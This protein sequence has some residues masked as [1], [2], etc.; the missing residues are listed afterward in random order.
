MNYRQAVTWSATIQEVVRD[1]RMPPWHA[2]PKYGR[3][4]N[5]PGLTKQERQRIDHWIQAG[6]PEGDPADL[7][8]QAVF[9][10]GW[11]IPNPNLVV[12]MPQA[13][14]VPADGVV[15]YHVVEVDP[16]FQEDKWIQTA[17]IRPGNRKVVHHC[18]VFLKAP[19]SELPTEQGTLGSFCL[20]ATT[21]G[22]PPLVLPPGMAKK[23]PAGWTFV[24]VVHYQ[25]IGSVQSD[26]TSIG[27]VFVDPRNVQKEVA[28]KLL[29]DLDFVIPP[30]ASDVRVEQS[31]TFFDDVLLLA[32]LPHM[33]VRGKSF[34]YE[35]VYPDGQGEILLDVP[36]YDFNWQHR[37]VLAEAKRLPA[38]TTLRCIATYDNSA[39]NPW[40]PDPDATVRVGRQSNDE[41]FNGYFEWCLADQDLTQPRP[42]PNTLWA[43]VRTVLFPAALMVAAYGGLLLLKRR[44]TTR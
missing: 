26:Q 33:H 32:M 12:S 30:R 16:G 17:E 40:N 4:A 9:S 11:S 42:A 3:F 25:P 27:L 15:D 14:T 13:F 5:D 39:A 43:I 2:N 38:G 20:A 36:R 24:F 28:T 6:T 8:P 21:P 34:R 7:P 10:D 41:M 22:T 1:G 37:Y 44:R 23:V 31:H 18:L 29:Y 19:G 35:A